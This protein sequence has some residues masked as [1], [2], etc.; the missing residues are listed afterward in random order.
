M[1]SSKF[2][3]RNRGE[4]SKTLIKYDELPKKFYELFFALSNKSVT[5]LTAPKPPLAFVT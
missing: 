4:Q 2:N 5:S 3:H 1:F